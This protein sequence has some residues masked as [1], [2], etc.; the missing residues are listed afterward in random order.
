MPDYSRFHVSQTR[1]QFSLL[2][3]SCGW[4]WKNVREYKSVLAMMNFIL[5]NEL[6]FKD[7]EYKR[8]RRLEGHEW[9]AELASSA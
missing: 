4:A 2:D 8:I 3:Q 7:E 1:G 9:E 5:E 6:Q